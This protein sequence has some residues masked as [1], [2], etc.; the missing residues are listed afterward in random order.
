MPDLDE[1]V[2]AQVESLL[3]RVGVP[4][5]DE[6]ERFVGDFTT[7]TAVLPLF[8][9]P[10]TV[11]LLGRTHSVVPRVDWHSVCVLLRWRRRHFGATPTLQTARLIALDVE[12]APVEVLDVW[13][14]PA[15]GAE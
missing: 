10:L 11:V 3:E 5:P 7:K 14:A 9:G 15:E 8:G 12:G 2:R 4:T 13:T 6:V 1:H